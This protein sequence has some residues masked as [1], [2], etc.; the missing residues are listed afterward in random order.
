MSIP[1]PPPL[2]SFPS[3][4][5]LPVELQ[6][7]IWR[8]AFRDSDFLRIWISRRNSRLHLAQRDIDACS[9]NLPPFWY[10]SGGASTPGNIVM[11]G[12]RRAG[13]PVSFG[14]SRLL[15]TCRLGRLGSLEEFRDVLAG[16]EVGTEAER[17]VV[18][19][20]IVLLRS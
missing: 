3:F 7:L 10:F 15:H 8:A 1:H 16:L 14:V 12:G 5:S 18:E 11:R 17:K 19:R 9:W 2:A 4:S 13:L 20:A 6:L